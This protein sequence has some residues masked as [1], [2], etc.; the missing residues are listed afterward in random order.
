[1]ANRKKFY[2]LPDYQRVTEDFDEYIAAWRNLAAPIE[3]ELGLTL[4]SYDPTFTFLKGN[5]QRDVTTVVSLPVWFVRDLA[6]VLNVKQG[7]E[8]VMS[9][10]LTEFDKI[11]K[12]GDNFPDGFDSRVFRWVKDA[13]A[14]SPQRA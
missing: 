12:R 5:P 7:T 4:H 13:V 14:S 10:V 8:Q 2:A 9:S 6:A 1:M 3:R 11:G